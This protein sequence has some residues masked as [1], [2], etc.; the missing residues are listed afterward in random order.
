MEG[1]PVIFIG[2]VSR[3]ETI[4]FGIF[5]LLDLR[6]ELLP[7]KGCAMNNEMYVLRGLR[8][9]ALGMGLPFRLVAT[10]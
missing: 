1:H 8:P 7:G 10:S 6:F 2:E 9:T 3:N 5:D 4:D